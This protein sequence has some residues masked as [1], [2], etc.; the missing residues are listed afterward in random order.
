MFGNYLK[1]ALRNLL[2]HKGYSAIE[3]FGF[4]SGLACC[5]TILLFTLD[6]LSYDRFFPHHDR[7]YRVGLNASLNNNLV[8]AAVS[9]PPMAETIKKE[10]PGIES[11]A[12]IW[13]LQK[14]LVRYRDK[15]ICEERFFW[16]DQSFFTVFGVTLIKGD[17]TAALTKPNTVV[18]TASAAK[19]Y[20]DQEEP[21]GK[22]LTIDNTVDYQVTGVVPDPPANSHMHYDFLGSMDSVALSKGTIWL[23]NNFYTYFLA[24]S[25]N[26][27]K[28][29]EEEVNAVAMKYAG[30]QVKGFLGVSLEEMLERGGRY[31]YFLQ[32][33]TDIHLK[34]HLDYEMEPNG[35]RTYVTICGITAL[36]IF[37]IACVNFINLATARSASRAKEIAVRKTLGSGRGRLV[38]QLL[39]E[40]QFLCLLSLIIALIIARM[41]LPFF[42]SIVGKSISFSVLSGSQFFI[43]LLVLLVASG[44]SAGAYPAFYLSSFEPVAVLKGEGG[45]V[46]TGHFLRSA[47]VVF[48]FSVSVFLIFCT[49]V[50]FQQMSYVQNRNLGFSKDQIL[51]I[52]KADALRTKMAAFKQE[53][54]QKAGVVASSNTSSLMGGSFSETLYQ[55]P[56]TPS[57]EQQLVWTVIVDDEFLRTFQIPL[58]AGRFFSREQPSDSSGGIVLN[59]SA[60]NALGLTKPVGKELSLVGAG[61][62]FTILGVV[63]DFHFQSLRRA[64]QPLALHYIGLE[65][66]GNFLSVKI[67]PGATG[68]TISDTAAT[69][70][71]FAGNQPFEYQFCDEYFSKTYVAE[72]RMATLFLSFSI[73][74]IVIAGSG[75]LGLA[76]LLT[77]QRKKE[78]GLR[79]ILGSSTRG[80]V[81]LLTKEFSKWIL[82]SILIAWPVGYFFMHHWLQ[83]FAY[84]T[85]IGFSDFLFSG[86]FAILIS[87]L[88]VSYQVI[89][90]ARAKPVDCLKYQ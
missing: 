70:R 58:V 29:L 46:K 74:A 63:K 4:A 13:S 78:I 77:H 39:L 68:E 9:C 57:S 43:A 42:G 19:K 22:V 21:V 73:L 1:V 25:G 65:D 56:N 11:A 83:D 33:L 53:L 86:F 38:M 18:V 16:V 67:K 88:T 64:I 71:K 79:K 31:R 37:L 50:I 24:R 2:R 90:A 7:I 36:G 40:V 59:E 87:L 17:T 54:S 5:F 84:R 72:E 14:P 49:M 55:L 15:T 20:F 66:V 34:S 85:S 12:R 60:V 52:P 82:I 51:V 30:P 23:S 3:L 76:A 10:I 32:P 45:G 69:W 6:Q 47:L 28:D 80:I 75:L 89:R 41:L 81:L 61:R 26:T 8:N 62:K 27:A 35:N 48:Q 44:V